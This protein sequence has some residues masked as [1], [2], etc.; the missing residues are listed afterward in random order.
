M[1]R[2]VLAESARIEGLVLTLTCG[3]LSRAEYLAVNKALE[4]LG[5]KWNRKQGGHVFVDDPTQALA[6]F[7]GGAALAKPPRT[8]EGYVQTPA[9]LAAMVIRDHTDIGRLAAGARVLEPSAGDGSFVHAAFAANPEV[10][11]VAVEPNAQRLARIVAR[12]SGALRRVSSTF[13]QFVAS[14]PGSFDAIV[15]N[16]PFAVPGAPS[17]WIDHVQL[18]YGLL[19]SGAR[20][21][22]IV[23]V[24]LLERQ[25]R[26][27]SA[28]RALTAEH[29][30]FTRL[31]DD[32]FKVS[33][34]GVRTAVMWLRAD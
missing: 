31:P 7:V 4:S 17:L 20:L 23:P 2:A 24:S 25:D 16:P 18:A 22:A 5:G 12:D 10:Q 29:G 8:S 3:Q 1:A 21:T 15:M 30:G 13:E 28:I 9:G 34:T 26:R 27:H 32:A 11:V 6:E 33:G 14:G 19:S